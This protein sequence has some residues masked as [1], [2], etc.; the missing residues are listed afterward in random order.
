MFGI[1]VIELMR[2]RDLEIERAAERARLLRAARSAQRGTR[3]KG[4]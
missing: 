1:N 3:G 4:R 2:Q